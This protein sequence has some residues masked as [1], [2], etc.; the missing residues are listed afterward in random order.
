MTRDQDPYHRDELS[1]R[2][3]RAEAMGGGDKIARQHDKGRLTARER[4]A[5]LVDADSFEE[6]WALAHSDLP[7]AADKTPADGKVCGFGT[8]D[9]RRAFV[10]ADDVTV[11]AGAGGRVGVR[12]QSRGMQYAV[13]K[14]YPCIHLGDAGGARVP[15]IM[16]SAGMMSMVYPIAGAP[17][18]DRRV[19]AI[20][21]IMGE[22][23]GGAAWSASVSDIVIQ[24]KGTAMCVGGPSILEIATG[25]RAD[26]EELGGWQLHARTTGQVDLFA[27]DD[28]H[29]LA[30]ARRALGYF[31]DH[32]GKLPPVWAPAPGRRTREPGFVDAVPADPRATYD[33]HHVLRLIA[34][35]DT[36]LELRPYFDP[37]LITA[38][39]RLD[40]RVVGFLAN[41]PKST[42]G[43]MGP[44]ACEKAV[45]FIALCDSFHIPLVF[46]H[47]T[48]GF[49]VSKAA[50]AR[51]MPL[52]IM[53]FIEALHQSTVPRV[54]LIVRKSYG[55]AHCNMAGGNM[56]SDAVLAWPTADVSFMAPA[57]AVN[58]VYGRKIA[59]MDDP[60]AAR[61]AYAEELA[62]ANAPWDAAGAGYV[63]RVIDPADTRLELIR[64]LETARGPDGEGGRSHRRL[65]NWPRMA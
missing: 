32:A 65:A 20:V 33:M 13:E 11:M 51:G 25:E 3:A 29:A 38:L 24:V 63:D 37:S 2:L 54:S 17:P 42:A 1:D 50:E 52:R 27:E 64:T 8:V 10:S 28:E 61:Q 30:L 16:G 18:R 48:P 14:G 40:G 58:V 35:P 31:P 4:I 49:F 21:A 23:F 57:V 60:E 46:V 45:A 39:G 19:P 55:M 6:R 56:D 62:R 44:G 53:N 22:C 15:D 43:A 36:L 5:R 9:G 41:N 47:D 7:E 34:D 59:K 12:K 26:T